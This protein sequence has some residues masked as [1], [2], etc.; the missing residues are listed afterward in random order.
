MHGGVVKVQGSNS[1][2]IW[3]GGL[4]V[5]FVLVSILCNFHYNRLHGYMF[6]GL[7]VLFIAYNFANDSLH[8][9]A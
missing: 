7:Y 4:L 1:L 9:A 6:V 2:S 3:M 5:F 8:F